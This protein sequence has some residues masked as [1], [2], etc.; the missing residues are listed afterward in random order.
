MITLTSNNNLADN[1]RGIVSLLIL[2]LF[3]QLL[4]GWRGD[5]TVFVGLKKGV[6]WTGSYLDVGVDSGHAVI[7]CS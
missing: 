2:I 7:L 3:L 6:G 1:E 4:G 5:M